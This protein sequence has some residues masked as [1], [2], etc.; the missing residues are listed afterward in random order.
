VAERGVL[1]Q[2]ID[3]G[4]LS[5]KTKGIIGEVD[6]VGSRN[7][8]NGI[9]ESLEGGRDL[10]KETGGEDIGQI[11][12]FEVLLG[13]EDGGETLGGTDSQSVATEMDLSVVGALSQ[14][15]NVSLNVLC[16]VKLEAFAVEREDLR[17][18]HGGV[19]D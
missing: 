16:S 18:G 17:R 13:C 4:C 15:L 12:D 10:G 14:R 19:V 6:S 11:S 5:V 3:E 1:G 9:K 2:E 7:L 8:E